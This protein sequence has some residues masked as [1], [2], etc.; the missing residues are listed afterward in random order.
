M[1]NRS[2]PPDPRRVLPRPRVSCDPDAPSRRATDGFASG[3]KGSSSSSTPRRTLALLSARAGRTSSCMAA[4][5]RCA[6]RAWLQLHLGGSH[7]AR[8]HLVSA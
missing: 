8:L 1:A 4:T 2:E 6:P 7:G 3:S 5:S